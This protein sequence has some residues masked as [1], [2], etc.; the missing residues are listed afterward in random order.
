[1]GLPTLTRV[2]TDIG[3]AEHAV[4]EARVADGDHP[5]FRVTLPGVRGLALRDRVGK[6][7][8]HIHELVRPILQIGRQGGA[9]ITYRLLHAIQSGGPGIL[10]DPM[11]VGGLRWNLPA[12]TATTA[13][14]ERGWR[15]IS[16]GQRPCGQGSHQHRAPALLP[17]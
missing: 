2:R 6:D 1:L 10:V 13:L 16:Q 5:A 3:A 7:G 17:T 12:G 14:G 8:I 11:H 15:Q 4:A 9:R